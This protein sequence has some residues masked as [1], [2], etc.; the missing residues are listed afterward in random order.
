M[1]VL[2]IIS[3]RT[4]LF[5]NLQPGP[6]EIEDNY[7]NIVKSL[8]ANKQFIEKTP[9]LLKI[10]YGEEEKDVPKPVKKFFSRLFVI[11]RKLAFHPTGFSDFGR[12]YF[13][14]EEVSQE[15]SKILET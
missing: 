11:P 12:K 2:V 3:N 10:L 6:R 9:E 7:G 4:K 1:D 13:E 15:I 8:E 14:T 5:K